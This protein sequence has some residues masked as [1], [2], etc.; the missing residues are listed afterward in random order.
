[1]VLQVLAHTR[2][3]VDR[4]HADLL[5]VFGVPHPGQQEDLGGADTAGG[6]DDLL[7]CKVL[8]HLAKPRHLQVI[9]LRDGVTP[10]R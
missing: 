1:M 9:L 4:S 2:Q 3:V 5:Q 7:A 6:Q 8:R 10:F